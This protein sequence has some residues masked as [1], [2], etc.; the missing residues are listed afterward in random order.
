MKRVDALR[1]VR[2]LEFEFVTLEQ[3]IVETP[4]LGSQNGRDTHLT[5]LDLK[6]QVYCPHTSISCR[7]R[8]SRSSVGSVTESTKG[9]TIDEN[10]RNDVDSLIT[11]ETQHLGNDGSGSELDEDDV[12]ET[13]S[14]ERVLEGHASLN[15]VSLDHSFENV[16]H[17]ERFSSSGEVISDGENSTQVVGR[18]TPFSSEPT[19]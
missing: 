3:Y 11:G 12:I 13:D 9:L 16:L 18:V 10:L 17:L 2:T 15:L 8:L 19:C 14:V 7:P 1:T 4:S 5:S 6:S